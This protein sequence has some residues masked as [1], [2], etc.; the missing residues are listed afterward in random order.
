MSFNP[1]E[2]ATDY[3]I[4]S[5]PTCEVCGEAIPHWREPFC[6][7][8]VGNAIYSIPNLTKRRDGICEAQGCASV[9]GP[10][11]VDVCDVC[12]DAAVLA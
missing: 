4:E 7:S 6:R 11:E 10:E 9:L 8:C 2:E 12:Q 3:D 1:Y 5:M